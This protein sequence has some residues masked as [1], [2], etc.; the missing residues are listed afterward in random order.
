MAASRPIF[1]RKELAASI[2]RDL[3][4]ESLAD[5]SSGM[6]LAAPRRIGKSTF[7]R[8][9]LIPACLEKGWLPVYV[10][11]WTN[12]EIDPAILI[13][14][15]IAKALADYESSVTKAARRSASTRSISFA[16]SAGISQSLSSQPGRPYLRRSTYCTKYQAR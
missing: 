4:G 13:S 16:R 1:K 12:R 14:G 15:A 6:F 8:A 3:A 5:Y 10:D 11:L 2:V 9:D 7:C